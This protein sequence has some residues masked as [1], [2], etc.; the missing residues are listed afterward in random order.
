MRQEEIQDGLTEA[1]IFE[2]EKSEQVSVVRM[3]SYLVEESL[4]VGHKGN[5]PLTKSH[6][7]VHET[8][9]EVWTSDEKIIQ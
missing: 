2:P 1:A 9:H 4:Y 3:N 8:V 7:N 6:K 5:L